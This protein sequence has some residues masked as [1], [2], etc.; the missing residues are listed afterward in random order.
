MQILKPHSRS[1]ESE[2][3][4][5]GPSSP[6]FNSPS[7]WL[8]HIVKFSSHWPCRIYVSGVTKTTLLCIHWKDSGDSA[9]SCTHG[10]GLVHWYSKN[11]VRQKVTGRVW[12]PH[13]GSLMI[14][15]SH[16]GSQ[17]A[18]SSPSNE[19]AAVHVMFLPRETHQTLGVIGFYW[20]WS[21]RHL[22]PS[23]C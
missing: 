10:S 3:L 16:E 22:L 5:L 11:L 2:S 19:N 18:P 6:C 20:G 17:R 4:E 9:Y 8:W 23:M 21:Y 14:S 15:S 13:A 7:G 12:N 1:T